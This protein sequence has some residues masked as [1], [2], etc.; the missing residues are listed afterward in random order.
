M[1]ATVIA[2][3]GASLFF[4]AYRSKVALVAREKMKHATGTVK[5]AADRIA[6]DMDLVC[7][8]SDRTYHDS[9]DESAVPKVA[10]RR[11]TPG[12]RCRR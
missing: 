12:T 3:Q 11:A 8:D 4:I 10:Q 5:A 1:P 6:E 7:Q 9:A 2:Q